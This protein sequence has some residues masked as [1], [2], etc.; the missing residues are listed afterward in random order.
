M[1]YEDTYEGE[2]PTVPTSAAAPEV[3]PTAVIPGSQVQQQTAL[4]QTG[5]IRPPAAAAPTA[6]PTPPS[7]VSNWERISGILSILGAAVQDIQRPP[8]AKTGGA[9]IARQRVME[10]WRA[11]G[12]RQAI[13]YI[14]QLRNLAITDPTKASQAMDAFMAKATVAGAMSGLSPQVMNAAMGTQT[15]FRRG[16][17]MPRLLEGIKEPP[18]GSPRIAFLK[19]ALQALGPEGFLQLDSLTKIMS[20]IPEKV[21]P[22]YKIISSKEQGIVAINPLT[23]EK[24]QIVK[25]GEALDMAQFMAMGPESVGSRLLKAGKDPERLW[26][27]MNSQ[28]PVVRETAINAITEGLVAT[29]KEHRLSETG[30]GQ[31]VNVALGR[32]KV[33][34][35]DVSAALTSTDPA[36]MVWASGVLADVSKALDARKDMDRRAMTIAQAQSTLQVQKETP[37]GM[38]FKEKAHQ[39]VEK[40]A[41]QGPK[42]QAGERPKLVP[43]NVGTTF[44]AAMREGVNL[45]DDQYKDLKTMQQAHSLLDGLEKTVASVF[46]TNSGS[47]AAFRAGKL[48]IQGLLDSNPDVALL[49]ASAGQLYALASAF[50]AGTGRALSDKDMIIIQDMVNLGYLQTQASSAARMKAVRRVVTNA[51]RIAAGVD[52]I[53]EAPPTGPLKGKWDTY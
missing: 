51:E 27:D 23:L 13:A 14:G 36:R 48:K 20:A 12:D 45:S 42:V 32:M 19:G 46:T 29:G 15:E 30:F 21:A 41:L 39:W 18:G 34:P 28:D 2:A 24:V 11:T 26:R 43:L 49:K 10:E 52:P 40:G 7:G 5:A 8:Q 1:A 17:V 22:S 9:A 31:E 47:L 33:N 44:E 38:A 6:T 16:M 37:I 35:L 53:H 25:P 50:G 3:P 4:Q